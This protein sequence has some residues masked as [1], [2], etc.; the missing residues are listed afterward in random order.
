MEATQMALL[1]PGAVVSVLS[2][3]IGGTVFARNRGGAYARAYA[4]PTRV[5][6]ETAQSVK[7]AFAAA[8][9]AYA[10]LTTA[11]IAAWDAYGQENPVSNRIGQLIT[12]KGQSWFVGCN[13][14]LIVAG[15]SQITL[16][17]IL[18]APVIAVADNP[19]VDV[20]D[21]LATIDV[22]A[23][24]ADASIRIAV[25]GARSVSAGK[26]YLENL[27]TTVYLSDAGASGTTLSFGSNLEAKLGS[28]QA[29]VTYHFKVVMLD[30]RTG[31][32]SAPQWLSTVA[33][34]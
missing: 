26:R 9:Q 10:N 27:Y 12:L 33:V 23:H 8:S 28:L 31:L 5:T 7:A 17:P 24:T 29:G 14:R 30:V 32:V 25:Y 15:E 19:V 13:A 1:V 22:A 21:T 34:A 6:S 2:G 3:K 4:I 16:P 18:A 11:Q 20:S